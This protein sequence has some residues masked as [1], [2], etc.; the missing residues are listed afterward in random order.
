MSKILKPSEEGF[1]SRNIETIAK[2]L[3][4]ERVLSPDRVLVISKLEAFRSLVRKVMSQDFATGKTREPGDLFITQIRGA[5]LINVT[6]RTDKAEPEVV[7]LKE[8]REN[9]KNVTGA[10]LARSIAA[11]EGSKIATGKDLLDFCMSK[12]DGK[13]VND[14]KSPIRIIE[15]VDHPVAERKVSFTKEE[16]AAA[17]S[18]GVATLENIGNGIASA[19]Q[20]KLIMLSEAQRLG[21]TTEELLDPR[22][23]AKMVKKSPLLAKVLQFFGK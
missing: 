18:E 17:N 15:N 12:I 19:E 14:P 23:I 7:W 16:G 20:A 1:W 3:A 8:L 11:A 4:G 9:N 13:N 2:N 22:N 21:I 5:P 6:G 10:A